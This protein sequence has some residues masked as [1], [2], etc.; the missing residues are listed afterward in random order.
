MFDRTRRQDLLAGGIS[1]GSEIVTAGTLT[2]VFI[3]RKDGM[4]VLVSNFHVF[5]GTPYKTKILQPGKYDGGSD[6]DVVGLLKRY[7]PI[8]RREKFPWWKKL[9]CLLF[10]WFL[11]EYC[12]PSEIPS[13]VDVAC[14]T[15]EARKPE[16]GVYLDNGQI[17]HP[18]S[19]HSGDGVTGSTVWK[20]GRTTGYTE[21]NVV[22]SSSKVKVWYGDKWIVFDDVVLVKGLARGGDSGSP[23]FLKKG[24]Q[25]SEEDSFVGILFAGSTDYF[26]FCKYKYIV[27]ELGVEWKGD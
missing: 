6:N 13:H 25:P 14:A 9:V 12:T 17:I 10:G 20:V 18:K 23:V 22:S 5:M 1:I 11:E 16:Y 15:I 27:E 8:E 7:V 4:N 19:T 2:G 21:G 3:D 24:E 26:I